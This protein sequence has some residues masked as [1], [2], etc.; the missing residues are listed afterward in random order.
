MSIISWA[1]IFTKVIVMRRATKKSDKFLVLLKC[2]FDDR[3][4]RDIDE[5]LIQ[6]QD[7]LNHVAKLFRFLV[8]VKV[9]PSHVFQRNRE[10]LLHMR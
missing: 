2:G 6:C 7:I 8:A 10:S 4:E 5:A 9:V 1:I 3:V